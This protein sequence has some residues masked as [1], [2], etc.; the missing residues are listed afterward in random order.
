MKKIALFVLFFLVYTQLASSQTIRQQL[1]AIPGV[2][3]VQKKAAKQFTE[4][5]TLLVT[6]PLDHS[7]PDKG[8]FTQRVFLSFNDPS[9]PM[10]MTTEGYQ[11]EYANNG[12]FVEELAQILKCNQVVVEHRYFA[13]SKPQ[14]AEWDYLT[15]EN[16][17]NDH[18][19]IIE[20]LKPIF[21]GKWITTGIS[22]GGQ[23]SI[24][25]RTFFPNDVDATVAYVAPIN[26]AQEDPRQIYFLKAVGPDST[27]NRI[28][29]Y[30]RSVLKNRTAIT[31]LMTKLAAKNNYTFVMSVDSTLDYL[32]LEYP[33]SFWQWGVK[34]SLIPKTGS[35]PETLWN[36]LNEIVGLT[37]YT[38]PGMLPTEAFFYQAYSEI[39]YYGYDTTNLSKYLSVKGGYISNKILIPKGAKPVFNPLTLQKVRDFI[40]LKGENILYLYGEI[41]PWSASAAMPTTATNSKRIVS[42]GNSHI[43]RISNL[44]DEQKAE[45]LDWLKKTLNIS[46]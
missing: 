35:S 11:A 4:S 16:A 14:N 37:A 1:E 36:H 41:D 45:A 44:S 28:I 27:R 19:R 8:T 7:N 24:Y 17:A 29:D 26:I 34:S 38:Q 23:T 12:L 5:Y 9:A 31:Q 25:H 43:T 40:A 33:F 20:M 32:I 10:V 15:V 18:H 39:G 6:Q 22:K 21:S 30:Q 3:V 42:L 13:G 2:K 46:F